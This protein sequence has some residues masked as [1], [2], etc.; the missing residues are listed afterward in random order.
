MGSKKK[1][2]FLKL[3]GDHQLQSKLEQVAMQLGKLAASRHDISVERNWDYSHQKTFV[4]WN[5]VGNPINLP[6]GD[7]R[8]STHLQYG[9]NL[10]ILKM[11]GF[12]TGYYVITLL[13][14]YIYQLRAH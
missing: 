3:L 7:G 12:T 8:Q 10:G 6:F 9:D 2:P 14:F 1:G 11:I 13:S 5:K 4:G